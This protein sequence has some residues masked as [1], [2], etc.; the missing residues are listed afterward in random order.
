[1][2]RYT[3]VLDLVGDTPVVDVSALSPRANVSILAKLEGRNPA[4]SVKDRVAVSLVN[5]AER[6]GLLIPGK[7]DQIL[8]EPSSGNTGIA[9]AMVCR[10]RGYHLKVVL[11]SNVSPERRQLLLA[12]GAEIIDSPGSE[13]SNGAVR[14]AQSLSAENPDWIFLY[15]YA[16]PA[17][18]AAHYTTTGPEILRDVPE[19]THFVAGLGTSG[20][21]MG[22]G[23]FLKEHKPETQIW[24]IEP[25]SGEMVDG[26]RSLEDGYIPPIFTDNHGAE[27]LDRKVVVRPKESIEW[28]RRLTEVGLFAG[29]SSGAIMAGAVKCALTIP[30]D[31]TA[32]IVTI[33]CDDGWKYL[34]TGAW[35]DDIDDVVERAKRIIYF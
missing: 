34:S 7:P 31:Q 17:N 10:L 5:A 35:S 24:A 21:L 3:S 32:T 18:P 6:D 28:V 12:W 9:L 25:P 1:M 13:G 19:I 15:Q 14:L 8:I 11:P 33:V 23:R 26:L 27:L 2:T 4:G 30:E 16:N 29:I 20:T 22:V